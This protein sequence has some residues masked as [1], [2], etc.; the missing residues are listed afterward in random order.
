MDPVAEFLGTLQMERGASPNTLLAY[1]R[2]LAGFQEFL[3]KEHRAFAQ[4][5][6]RDLTRYLS[7]LR[8]RGLGSKSV[9]RHLSAVRGLYRHLLEIGGVTRD[10]TEHLDSPKHH[11]RLPRVLSMAD[12]VAL[13]EAPDIGLAVDD[14]GRRQHVEGMLRSHGLSVTKLPH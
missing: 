9:A 4:T 6:A 1:R 2:D 3:R 14:E 7:W 10:P 8:A 11:R 5:S 13:I 12:A